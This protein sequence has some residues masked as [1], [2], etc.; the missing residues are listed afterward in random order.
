MMSANSAYRQNEF[1]PSE[2]QL[3]ND[4]GNDGN[5]GSNGVK[6]KMLEPDN[7]LRN[8]PHPP[9]RIDEFVVMLPSRVW[10]SRANTSAWMAIGFNCWQKKVLWSPG[11]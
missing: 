6:V 7:R 1:A 5:N 10:P 9:A 2:N 3:R 8:W 4:D 11:R